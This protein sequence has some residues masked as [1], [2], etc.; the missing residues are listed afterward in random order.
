[1]SRS[2]RVTKFFGIAV[3]LAILAAAHSV[4]NAQ[5]YW[6]TTG[7]ANWSAT[8][9]SWV[10]GSVPNS[11]TATAYIGDN[12]TVTVDSTYATANLY[13][14]SNAGTDPGNGTVTFSSASSRLNVNGIV[15]IGSATHTGTLNLNAGTLNI[16]GSTGAI[17]TGGTA[18]FNMS[19]GTLQATNANVN[20]AGNIAFG[21]GT[22]TDTF[23]TA[24]AGSITLS[25]NITDAGTGSLT[26]VGLNT[27]TLSGSSIA[28]KGTTTVGG[29]TL[30]L[31]NS[32]LTN[33]TALALQNGG[34]FQL[35]SGLT[36]NFNTLTVAVGGGS[37]VPS[38]TGT[39]NFNTSVTDNTV[40]GALLV[41]AGPTGIVTVPTAPD[42]T[43]IYGGRIVY[44]DGT[45]YNWAATTTSFGQR[46]LSGYASY[47]PLNTTGGTDAL[48]SQI[49]GDA[50]L[51][52]S[53]QTNTLSIAPTA[54]TTLHLGGNLLTLNDGGL[55][56]TGSNAVTI[57]DNASDT[58]TGGSS[59]IGS[60][61]ELV[62]HQYST[63]PLTINASIVTN[64]LSI[65]TA[66][67][68]A[69]PG[70]AIL[71]G[72]NTYTGKTTVA[73]GTLVAPTPR[74]WGA[75]ALPATS[76]SL[77]APRCKSTTAARSTGPRPKSPAPTFSTPRPSRTFL[78]GR[79]WPST[80]RTPPP[81]ALTRPSSP[82]TSV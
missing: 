21:S 55:L 47:S 43:G 51:A 48:N 63:A 56:V 70:T 3:A 38:S 36:Q 18:V 53:V 71:N 78:S 46:T 4:A 41:N 62:I 5:Y 75:T 59:T 27:L 82:A 50:T 25:G 12:G 15:T 35:G 81:A 42:A 24:I 58:I 11:T 20:Y 76:Q 40:G 52:A 44:F 80:R 77:R 67:T 34:A 33:S 66:L 16:V 68:K 74:H 73:G 19:G 13:I 9:S 57:G 1:M 6:G 17:Q 49:T 30:L 31:S 7:T 2:R 69:G 45:N 72:T 79:P 65:S 8:S 26:K 54:P 29:G 61:D 64:P 37:I 60:T 39:V 14:G 22:H 32:A 28:Y 10:G 23:N